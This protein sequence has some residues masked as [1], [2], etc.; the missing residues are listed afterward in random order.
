MLFQ[1]QIN[2]HSWRSPGDSAGYGSGVGT[3]LRC[4][5]GSIPG[6][7]TC[8]CGGC[9]KR[10][11]REREKKGDK[12]P[13]GAAGL[14]SGGAVTAAARVTAVAQVGSLAQELPHASEAKRKEKKRKE[15][16]E[17]GGRS[18]MYIS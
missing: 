2:K 6:L 14:G 3:G 9:G 11:K 12:F 16:K 17:G 5:L 8:A 10:K 1:L 4:G 18:T 13:C 15:K 7:R